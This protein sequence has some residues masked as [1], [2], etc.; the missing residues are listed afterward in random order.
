MSPRTCNPRRLRIWPGLGLTVALLAVAVEAEAAPCPP[1][2]GQT[3]PDDPWQSLNR[4]VYDFSMGLDRAVVGPIAHGYARA[5]P[6]PLRRRAS[7]F[8]SNL[9]EPGTAINDLAQAHPQRAGRTTVRFVLNS[10]VG[11]LGL[12]D[13]ATGM[14]LPTHDADFGQTLGRWGVKPG[15]YIYVPIVG[16]QNLRDGIGRLVD[17]A[18]DPVTAVVG[19]SRTTEGAARTGLTGAERRLAQDDSFRALE[20][21]TDP[22]AATRS[23]YSQRRVYIVQQATGVAPDLPDFDSAPSEPCDP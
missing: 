23:G 1:V 20:D 17:I 5:V 12:F 13:V 14:G 15:P 11:L 8:I 16:P 6:G 22:Y 21:A 7:A 10:T 19:G 9:E 4:P 2:A 3:Q 18:L